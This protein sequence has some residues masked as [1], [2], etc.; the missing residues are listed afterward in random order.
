MLGHQ[1][2]AKTF[3]FVVDQPGGPF[4]RYRVERATGTL[5]L[6]GVDAGAPLRYF[7]RGHLRDAADSRGAPLD[8]L[9]PAKVPTSPGVAFRVRP[10]G[11][12]DATPDAP[13][14]VVA[15]METDADYVDVN[16]LG[17]LPLLY[18]TAI[19][20]VVGDRSLIAGEQ[21]VGLL[22]QAREAGARARAL[23][24]TGEQLTAWKSSDVRPPV[25]DGRESE[26]HTLAEHGLRRLPLAF[27][28]YVERVLLPSERLLLFIHRPRLSGRGF[29]RLG[30]KA[31]EAIMVVTDRQLLFVEDVLSPDATNVHWG[32]AARICAIERVV[33]AGCVRG[34]DRATLIIGVEALGGSEQLA[35][36]FP[37]DAGDAVANAARLLQRF[38]SPPGEATRAVRRR[39]TADTLEWPRGTVAPAIDGAPEWC[40]SVCAADLLVA[41]AEPHTRDTGM[42]RL[43]VSHEHLWLAQGGHN[44]PITFATGAISSIGFTLSPVESSIEVAVPGPHGREY[45]SLLFEYTESLPF[46]QS[47]IAL[48]QLLGQPPRV[49]QVHSRH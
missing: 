9:I 27:Q 48:R 1:P 31:P 3:V 24:R 44:D 15:V 18:R 37:K 28:E 22:A 26:R 14:L 19:E 13:P 6:D 21:M 45:H 46:L 33:E 8:A 47:L 23:A 38:G 32:Y 41:Y 36:A 11:I 4:N 2:P 30:K 5:L 7:E 16:A 17:D 29:L 10:I 12:A 40:E 34:R 20:E 25:V 49:D 35:L 43:V 39:Y 42:S